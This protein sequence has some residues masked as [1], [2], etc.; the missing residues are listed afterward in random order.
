MK[1]HELTHEEIEAM[2]VEAHKLGMTVDELAAE[3]AG[4]MI[5]PEEKINRAKESLMTLVLFCDDELAEAALVKAGLINSFADTF[6]EEDI[7]SEEKAEERAEWF[8]NRNQE[9]IKVLKVV[10]ED[11]ESKKKEDYMMS[12]SST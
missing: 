2:K 5:S 7:T 11:L 12:I 6:M 3:R 9:L 8:M 1:Y 4:V 10:I